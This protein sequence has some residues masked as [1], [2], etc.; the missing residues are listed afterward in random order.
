MRNNTSVKMENMDK[1]KEI[2]REIVREELRK[3]RR[4]EKQYE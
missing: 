4:K 2:I 3:M 1:L